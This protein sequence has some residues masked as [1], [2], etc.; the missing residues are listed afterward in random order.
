MAFRGRNCERKSSRTW[1]LIAQQR[2]MGDAELCR[3]LKPGFDHEHQSSTRIQ[4]CTNA[5]NHPIVALVL[6][7]GPLDIV[8]SC[9]VD[10]HVDERCA[11]C[12][13][14]A[15]RTFAG[16]IAAQSWSRAQHSQSR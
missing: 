3:F 8:F 9:A 12:Q 2:R 11:A 5:P 6:A 10:T 15:S 1:P 4:A 14:L 16:S 7:L 13:R